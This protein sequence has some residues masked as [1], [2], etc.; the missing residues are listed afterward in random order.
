MPGQWIGF[1]PCGSAFITP[2]FYLPATYI[3]HA[4]GQMYYD[5]NQE[6]A[7]GLSQAYESVLRFA[8]QYH[9]HSISFPLLSSG[10]FGYTKKDAL[11]IAISTF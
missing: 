4:V 1:C 2:S 8:K 3:I 10:I 9:C 6:E 11:D 7:K 5:G